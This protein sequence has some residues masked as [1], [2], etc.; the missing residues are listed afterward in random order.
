MI[1]IGLDQ[2]TYCSGRVSTD[3]SDVF[4]GLHSRPHHLLIQPAIQ[5]NSAWPSIC[6]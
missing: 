2:H 3:M 4:H 6:E 1:T 5:I